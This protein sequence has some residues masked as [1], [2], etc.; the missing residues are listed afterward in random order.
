MVVVAVIAAAAG[1]LAARGRAAV[2]A[3]RA[4]QDQEAAGRARAE[5]DDARAQ[6][7]SLRR[8][9]QD[10]S[11]VAAG[12]QAELIAER[13]QLERARTDLA[14]TAA[15]AESLSEQ[16]QRAIATQSAVETQLDS[17]R[18]RFAGELAQ[19]RET[20]TQM[21]QAVTR[22]AGE[23]MQKSGAELIQR[24]TEMTD[25]RAKAAVGELDQR[26]AATEE[27]L[28]P[29]RQELG[30]FSTA[31]TAFQENN[32]GQFSSVTEQIKASNLA[33]EQLRRETA[34]L[35]NALRKPDV[36]GQWGE[37]QLRTLVEA[38][39]M[40]EHVD[41]EQQV[42]VV[43]DEDAVLRPDMVVH[44]GGGRNVVVDAKA[45][46]AA[47]LDAHG[48]DDDDTRKKCAAAHARNVR[49]HV[50]NLAGKQYWAQFSSSPEYV[51]M[52]LPADAFLHAALDEDRSLWDDAFRSKVILTTPT[53]LLMSLRT[54]AQMWQQQERAENADQIAQLGRDLYNRFAK[55][56]VHLNATGAGLTRAVDA[57]NKTIG[58]FEGRVIPGARKLAELAVV[59]TPTKDLTPVELSVRAVAFPSPVDTGDD[60]SV[61]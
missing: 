39:G 14:D 8:Q 10:Q 45:P 4:R 48:A 59:T 51:L 49:R 9:L 56:A 30:Q 20:Q 35:T 42:R 28:A 16:L 61:A 15:K 6:V 47:F 37:V 18:Q 21:Q 50:D 25:H 58:S 57:F 7:D 44:L 53:T 38:A 34:Q 26:K 46:F 2:V 19:L 60:T 5:R 55:M 31:L 29:L 12:L 54:V 1:Y 23:V 43:T 13:D 17:E 27:M 52:F 22:M 36:R 33:S 41:F 24:F 32:I 40:V 3:E 11:T